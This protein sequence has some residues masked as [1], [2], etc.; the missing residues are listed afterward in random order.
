[1]KPSLLVPLVLLA[2][3]TF[4]QAQAPDPLPHDSPGEVRLPSGKLQKDE[5]LRAEH[6][7]NLADVADLVKLSE[8]LKV[9]LEK[10]TQYVLS[11]ASI[12]KTEE[13]EKLARRIRSR[14]KRY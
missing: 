3:S 14:M 4:C 2:L 7:K 12:K 9:D 5:I 13:I 11:V 8:E 1:M 6:E 10:N